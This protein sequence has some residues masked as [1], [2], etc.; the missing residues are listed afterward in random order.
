MSLATSFKQVHCIN[1]CKK[2]EVPNDFNIQSV[3]EAV[4]WEALLNTELAEIST[5]QS[6]L[7]AALLVYT[8][9]D[10]SCCL[11]C[12]EQGLEGLDEK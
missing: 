1:A 12:L 7:P 5:V 9:G 2:K 4:L 8:S 6:S 11:L 3:L 10:L